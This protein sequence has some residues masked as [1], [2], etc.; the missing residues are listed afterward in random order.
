M[1]TGFSPHPP[2]FYCP[3]CKRTSFV[4][5]TEDRFCQ[6]CFPDREKPV[7]LRPPKPERPDYPD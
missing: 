6:Y 7:D 3:D 2:F 4:G 5:Q 1:T